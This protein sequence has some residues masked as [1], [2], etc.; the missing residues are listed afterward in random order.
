MTDERIYAEKEIR[1]SQKGGNSKIYDLIREIEE[2]RSKLNGKISK[3]DK[4]LTSRE[5]LELSQKLDELIVKYL[6]KA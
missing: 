5:I 4:K 3:E 2:I 1:K 6:G